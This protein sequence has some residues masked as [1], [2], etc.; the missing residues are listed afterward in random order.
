MRPADPA[1]TGRG[2][3]RLG[4]SGEELQ[5]TGVGLVHRDGAGHRRPSVRWVVVPQ[6]PGKGTRPQSVGV[7]EVLVAP[8][9]QDELARAGGVPGGFGDEAGLADAGIALHEHEPAARSRRGTR[10]ERARRGPAGGR[11]RESGPC[12]P[13]RGPRSAR[14]GRAPPGS[15]VRRR[16]RRWRRR[17]G[18]VEVGFLAQHRHLER[19][20]G[21]AGVDAELLAQRLAEVPVGPEGV[22]L[23]AGPVQRQHEEAGEALAQRRGRDEGPELPDD[24]GVPAESQLGPDEVL[25]RG[26]AHLPEPGALGLGEPEVGELRQGR[27]PPQ[28]QRPAQRRRRPLGRRHQVGAGLPHD[29]LEAGR[30]DLAPVDPEHV[31]GL[32]CLEHRVAVPGNGFRRQRPAQ[33]RD[34]GLQRVGRAR[35]WVFTPQHVGQQVP[36]DDAV[37][38]DEEHGQHGPHLG[39]AD[40]DGATVELDLQRAQEPEDDAIPCVTHPQPP[41][42][43]TPVAVRVP[44]QI[45]ERSSEWCSYP[46]SSM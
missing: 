44:E 19:G 9:V 24:L 33:L 32:S 14:L 42:R 7:A 12:R 1:E 16:G 40:V 26:H 34:V 23:T 8:P 38:V 10:L 36:R 11:R 25:G 17:R 6:D 29:V 37:G 45:Y 28:G 18:E 13:S 46:V 27:A 35:G 5:A 15:R 30:V 3:E 31:A 39:G 41:Y 4:R 20:Q 43:R 2:G 22:G 21:G